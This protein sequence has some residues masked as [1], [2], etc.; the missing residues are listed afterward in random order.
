ME[1]YQYFRLDGPP[2][3]PASP[4]GAVYLSPT[5]LEGLATLEKGLTSDLSGL[6]LLTGEA[7]TGKTTLIYSLLQR[8]YKRVRVAHIDDPKLSFLEMMQVVMTQLQ[9]YP[10]GTTKLDYLNAID[11]LL[12]LH[13]KEERIAIVVDEAQVLSD[14]TL[15]ELRLVSNRGQRDDRCLQ[16]VL[17][18]QPELAER[19]KKPELRQLNQ[20]ISS[21]GMLRPLTSAEAI[22]YVESKL[23]AQSST[24]AALFEPRALPHLLKRSDGIPRKIN[25][26]CHTALNAAFY[27]NERKVSVGT[28]KKTA[29]EYHDSVAITKRRPSRMRLLVIAPLVVGVGVAAL[30]LLGVVYPNGASDWV[31]N[32]TVSFGKAKTVEQA[33]DAGPLD[34]GVKPINPAA[35]APQPVEAGRSPRSPMAGPMRVPGMRIDP[36]APAAAA[37]SAGDQTGAPAVPPQRRQVTVRPGDTLETIAMRYYGSKDGISELI[38]ANPQL[39]DINRLSVGQTI[40]LPSSI[41]PKASHNQSTADS[42]E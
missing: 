36:T 20:R 18:G 23:I 30:L 5:H 29:L 33:D 19:L 31:R 37:V 32:H 35:L 16:L 4:R 12:D 22:T 3:Q 15:E 26:L 9:L 10:A 11:H 6:T 21:R 27:A 41:A 24:I 2:F 40:Y 13:G 14:D 39:T 1:Y 42:V 25:M 8:D 17:V 7:G 28:A 34:F 38:E